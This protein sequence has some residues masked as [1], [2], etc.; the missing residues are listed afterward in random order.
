[1]RS[2]CVLRV[3]LQK[4]KNGGTWKEWNIF[5]ELE[6][7]L[8]TSLDKSSFLIEW[9]PYSGKYFSLKVKPNFH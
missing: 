2:E 7:P 6:I 1:M 9:R 8:E 4:D 3:V 5:T